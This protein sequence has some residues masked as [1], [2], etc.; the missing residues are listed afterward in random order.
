MHERAQKL[1]RGYNF[2][3][4]DVIDLAAPDWFTR[5]HQ[6]IADQQ[7]GLVWVSEKVAAP[8]EDDENLDQGT[9]LL[10]RSFS[11]FN[12]DQDDRL[13]YVSAPN[14][15]YSVTTIGSEMNRSRRVD[16]YES[17]EEDENA[18]PFQ[19]DDDQQSYRSDSRYGREEP[20]NSE[21]APNDYLSKAKR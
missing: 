9:N 7:N 11:I 2:L 19:F 5:V 8:E 21:L 15:E 4:T 16:D 18:E 14:S 12:L 3:F 17:E 13:S 20:S 6:S 1:E 10:L